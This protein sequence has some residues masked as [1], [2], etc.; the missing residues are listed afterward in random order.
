MTRDIEI[1]NKL[2][3]TSVEVGWGNWGNSGKGYQ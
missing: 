2:K 3:V 1:K